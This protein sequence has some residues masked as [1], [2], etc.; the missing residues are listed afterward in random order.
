M[1]R[2]RRSCIW[3]MA[4]RLPP[5]FHVGEIG[6]VVGVIGR[7]VAEQVALEPPSPGRRPTKSWW[8]SSCALRSRRDRKPYFALPAFLIG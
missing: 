8:T 4:Q 1:S 7:V 2:R 5:N 3:S 6:D